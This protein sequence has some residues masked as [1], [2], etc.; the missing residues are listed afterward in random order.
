MRIL[1]AE[2][3]VVNQVVATKMLQKMG[4]SVKVAVN[5]RQALEKVKSESIDLIFMDG[6]MPEM[7]G[8]AATRAIREW[9]RARGTH[10]PIIAMTAMALNSD[11]EV[12]LRAGMDAFIPKPIDMKILRETIHRV[13]NT[14]AQQP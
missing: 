1:L 14:A 2:D 9:E 8:I 5:G 13:M 6:H 11:R 10:I 12:C 3:N 7:D 4:H